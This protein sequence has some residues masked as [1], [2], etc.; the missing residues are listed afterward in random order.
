MSAYLCIQSQSKDLTLLIKLIMK[1][2]PAKMT[3]LSSRQEFKNLKRKKISL[4]TVT[5][6]NAILYSDK[7]NGPQLSAWTWI[8]LCINHHKSTETRNIIKNPV[9][10]NVC[11]LREHLSLCK[12]PHTNVN[13][14][15][16]TLI[17]R[18]QIGEVYIR[19]TLSSLFI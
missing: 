6:F 10:K 5:L 18:L 11:I 14:L 15:K 1:N 4:Y 17:D 7:V 16:W 9:W 8:N 3:K 13:A 2:Q 12:F 19:I